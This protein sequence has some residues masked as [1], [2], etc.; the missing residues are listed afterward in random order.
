M[1]SSNQFANIYDAKLPNTY[2]EVSKNIFTNV[3]FK[4]I[5]IELHLIKVIK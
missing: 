5:M 1:F 3:K 2:S 4:R